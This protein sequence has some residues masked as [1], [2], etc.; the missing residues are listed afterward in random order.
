M[1]PRAA[2]KAGG[3]DHQSGRCVMEETIS[4]SVVPPVGA[5][6]PF[7][8]LLSLDIAEILEQTY[9]LTANSGLVVWALL[10]IDIS[11]NELAAKGLPDGW[12][13]QIY[14]IG[15]VTNRRKLRDLLNKQFPKTPT[16]PLPV[17]TRRYDGSPYGASYAFKYQFVR[18]VSYLDERKNPPRWN[19]RKTRLKA[20]HLKELMLAL[21]QIG[22]T[23]RIAFIGLAAGSNGEGGATI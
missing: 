17:R 18:R 21:D 4:M 8:Q 5:F 9:E 1:W 16:V 22:F 14:F 23:S 6:A 15:R 12:Q 2:K 19:T 7:G 11:F 13:V 10:A 20:P 3:A